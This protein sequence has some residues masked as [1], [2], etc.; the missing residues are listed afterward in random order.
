MS[1]ITPIMACR[2]SQGELDRDY[3]IG[4]ILKIATPVYEAASQDRLRET[5]PVESHTE[6]TDRS[7]YSHLE[8]IARTLAGL[9]PWLNLR[10]CDEPE[11]KKRIELLAMVKQSLIV[12]MN[13][14]SKD[15]IN[16]S[17]SSQPLVDAAFLAEG[18]MRC[19]DT[20][21]VDLPAD[22]QSGIIEALISTRRVKLPFNNWLLFA[23]IVEACLCRA[24]AGWDRVRVD[25]ALKQHRQWYKG[26]G[27]YGD[28]PDFHWDYYNS[29]VIHPMLF[30]V[31]HAGGEVS[32]QCACDGMK[33]E[34]VKR[35]QRYA[36]V[37]ERLIAPDASFPPLGRSLTYRFGAFHAL[38]LAS[39]K[40]L[41]PPEVPPAGVRCG[42]TAVIRRMT[43]APGTFDDDGWLRIG[44]CGH[45]PGLGE[46]YISTGSLYLCL[47]GM[48]PLGLPASD[49]FWSAPAC[50]W[51]SRRLWNGENSLC[52]AAIKH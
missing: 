4:T 35:L 51:T 20:V 15:F 48:L 19:W 50:D 43:E 37:Q 46:N 23:A 18:L 8:A 42:L 38:A 17:G 52:D 27:A 31:A 3:W 26:D 11:D 25:Y 6:M 12:M 2:N 45:Q 44:F 34:I 21:W 49:P 36:V 30:D 29:F 28:G 39:W 22:T 14:S 9:A 13:P 24:G 10:E 41:L 16:L 40:S 1:K 32:E 33:D 5:M 47:C 7:Q